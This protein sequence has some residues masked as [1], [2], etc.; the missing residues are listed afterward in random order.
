LIVS[1]SGGTLRR[2]ADAPRRS[3]SPD[4]RQRDAQR[5]REALLD[6]A[7]AEFAA[8][9]LAGARVS[10]IAARAG[11]NKQLISYYFGGKEGLYQAIIDRW[12]EQEEQLSE[13]GISLAELAWRYLEVGHR[14][15]DLQRLFIR[16][17]IDQDVG[18]VAHEPDAQELQDLR[19]RQA[20]GEIAEELDPAFV[21]MVLQATV[22]SGVVFPGD[23]KRLM[24]LDP[25]SPDYLEHMR[26]QLR[27]LVGRLA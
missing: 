7:R 20:A 25:A 16:E 27:L 18:E 9:G 2:V 6:A 15:P 1:T 21:L 3:P 23:V 8:K 10:E 5:T 19:A 12:H 17:S 22:I 11:V 24:G 13:P 26:R 4:E 14:Q